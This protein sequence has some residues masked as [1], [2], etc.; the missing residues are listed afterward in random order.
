M[1]LKKCRECGHEVS[2]GA[3]AC[4]NCG[5]R[6]P[7]SSIGASPGAR[8]CLWLIGGL[9]LIGMCTSLLDTGSDAGTTSRSSSINRSDQ[10]GRRGPGQR[11]HAPRTINVRSGPGTNHAVTYQLDPADLTFVGSPNANGWAAVY[12]GP[13][14]SD[15]A[16]YVKRELLRRGNPPE[17]MMMSY[18]SE[19]IDRYGSSAIVAR[20]INT[21][22]STMRYASVEWKILEPGGGALIETAFDN[23]SNLGPGQVWRSTA[24]VHHDGRYSYQ[25]GDLSGY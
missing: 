3:K 16:G 25:L 5:V 20:I 11:Y 24:L 23:I 9:V 17:L 6:Y 22:N 13:A 8:G 2:T 19:Y 21:T 1:A 10:T 15:T 4:P 18:D 12:S 7:A 14:A